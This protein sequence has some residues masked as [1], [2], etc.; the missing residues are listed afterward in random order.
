MEGF[1]S[2]EN[3]HRGFTLIEALVSVVVLS[4]GLLGLGQLQARLWSF[5][6][7]LH[8]TDEAYLLASNALEKFVMAQII[9]ADLIADTTAQITAS[10]TQFTVD[11]SPTEQPQLIEARV[12]VEWEHQSGLRSLALDSAIYTNSRASDSR[13]L[14]AAD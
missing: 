3:R 8:S 4:I 5:S 7:D 13:L 2:M 6:G 10:A 14:L 12:R 1:L 9:A 11:L